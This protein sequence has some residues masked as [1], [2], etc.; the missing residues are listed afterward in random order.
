M[1]HRVLLAAILVV[2]LSTATSVVAGPILKPRKYHG[3]IPRSSVTLSLGFLGGASNAEMFDYL[4]R[5]VP[6]FARDTTQ[7]N[8]FGNAPLIQVS[9]AYKAHPQVAVRGDLYGALLQ[10]DWTGIVVPNIDPPPGTTDQ[11]LEPVLL[12]E[13]TFDV[14]L[15]ALEVAAVYYFTDASVREFQPYI[16]GG[17][18]FGFPYQKFKDTQTVT[19]PDSDPGDPDYVPATERGDVF[20]ELEKNEFSFEAGV[21]GMLGALYYFD[22]NWAVSVEGRLQMLQSKFPLTVPNEQGN[23]EEVKFDVD[24]SGFVLAAGISYAF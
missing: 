19:V 2:V 15:F 21:Q 10:S 8:D 7:S 22:N 1:K 17:F 13:K 18:T 5:Q 6:Q 11:W 24:Y 4:S 12:S 9:Y 14:Y 16:G 23:P 3:P 20:Y